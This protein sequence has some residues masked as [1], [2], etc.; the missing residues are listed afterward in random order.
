MSGSYNNKRWQE[1]PN[2]EEEEWD[3]DLSDQTGT[4][5]INAQNIPCLLLNA[6]NS[7]NTKSTPKID[8]IPFILPARLPAYMGGYYHPDQFCIRCEYR[9]RTEYYRLEFLHSEG[10]YG[11]R[12]SGPFEVWRSAYLNVADLANAGKV[13]QRD[14]KG[15][16][17]MDIF[18]TKE[19]PERQAIDLI[20]IIPGQSGYI[21]FRWMF[22]GCIQYATLEVMVDSEDQPCRIQCKF[23]RFEKILRSWPDLRRY[24]RNHPE[25]A[26][27]P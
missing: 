13:F 5:S 10:P 11:I 21:F 3:E 1:K 24:L 18:N 14:I 26:P 20:P 6:F 8:I 2:G 23:G 19:D 15:E 25:L 27:L 22:R 16:W 9:D 12:F 17:I 4:Y 7:T